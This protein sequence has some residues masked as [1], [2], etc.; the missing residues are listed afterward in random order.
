MAGLGIFI[1]IL[2]LGLLIFVH[3]AGHF[4]AGKALKLKVT[5]FFIGLP[6][7]KPL[8]KFTRG[9]TTYGIKPVLFGGYVKF[10]EFLSLSEAEVETVEPGSPAEAAGLKK[11]DLITK[12]N[13]KDAKHWL[14]VFNLLKAMPNEKLKVGIVRQEQEQELDVSMGERDGHGWFGAGP[15][16][17]DDLTIEE[18]PRTMEGLKTWRKG[19]IIAAGPVMNII[20]AAVLITG[21]LLVGFQEPTT[22]IGQVIKG[23]PA[24]VIG[25]KAGDKI[26]SI[27]GRPITKWQNVTS[28]IR[29]NAGREIAIRVARDGRLLF[30]KPQLRAR[31]TQGLL[32]I[33]TKLVRQPRG[34]VQAV[35]E[36]TFFIYQA[37][38]T[39]LGFMT[40]L[41]THPKAVVGQ[42]RSPIGVVQETAPIAQRDLLEYIITLAGI[43]VAIG[44]FNFLPLPPLDGGRIFISAV[45]FIM[46]R[47][48]AKESLAFINVAGLSLLLVLM[49]YVIT[50][51]IFRLAAPG[52]G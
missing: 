19:L 26:I 41:V 2:G 24:A 15:A 1:S 17:T 30:F 45:E 33:A 16:A 10:P 22:T 32:G 48:M 39:I 7:G 28:V 5:E 36:G 6:I 4:L 31:S 49:T 23:G 35:K 14:D 8:I 37:S 25:I 3:E 42:L 27:N 13:D 40:K 46:R 44:I 47:P 12:I 11:G 43:S 50:A 18:L 51:D 9:E 20:L 21:A 34:P 29:H 38:R 52:G